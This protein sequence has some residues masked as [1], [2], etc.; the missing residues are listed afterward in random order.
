M[1]QQPGIGADDILLAVTTL[2]FDIAGLEIY[3]P[4]TVGTHVVVV[5][6]DTAR[7][8]LRL[9]R[10]MERSGATLMQATPATWRLLVQA[11]WKGSPRMRALCGGEALPRD[12]A[13]QLTDRVPSLW[14][15]Y[16]PTETTIWSGVHRV[17]G[18]EK[19]I[20]IGRPISNTQFYVLDSQRQPVPVGVIGELYIG[21]HG[22]ARGYLGRPELTAEKFVASPFH[23][24]PRVRIYRTGDQVLPCRRQHPVAGPARPPGEDSRLSHRA[25]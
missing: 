24:D 19:T 20:P 9:V 25:G 11:G 15:M 1:R 6:S 21:G 22:L 14:N 23:H 4:M 2:S 17:S 12:L 7:D 3:L 10:E 13:R 16:G 18:Q 5:S 8:G